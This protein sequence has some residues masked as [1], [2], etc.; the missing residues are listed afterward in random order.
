MPYSF[1]SWTEASIGVEISGHT[2][3]NQKLAFDFSFRVCWSTVTKMI[4]E[5]C[6][7]ILKEYQDP[8][9]SGATAGIL[10]NRGGF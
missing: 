8:I 4:N 10:R 9:P 1:G 3:F 7:A 5:M 2:G 6:H